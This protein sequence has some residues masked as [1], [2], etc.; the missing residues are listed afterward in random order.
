M[1][2]STREYDEIPGLQVDALLRKLAWAL[3]QDPVV[4][5]A[6]PPGE[7]RYFRIDR[8][9]IEAASD[10]VREA[11]HRSPESYRRAVEGR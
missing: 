2:G 8:R 5:P 9:F 6:K 1:S 10:V 7:I 3:R 4:D 11:A